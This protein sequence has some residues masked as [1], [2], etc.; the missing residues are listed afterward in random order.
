MWRRDNYKKGLSKAFFVAM[1][2]NEPL[3]KDLIK[4]LV[5]IIHPSIHPWAGLQ[6]AAVIRRDLSS[7]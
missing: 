1:G 3:E 4:V 6:P 2:L 7:K 5:V